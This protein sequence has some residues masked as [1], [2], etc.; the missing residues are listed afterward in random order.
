MLAPL[1]PDMFDPACPSAL[2]P[3]RVG[4]KWGAMI[5]RCLADGPRRFGELRVPLHGITPK[6]LTSSLRRLERDG[7]VSRTELAGPVRQVEYA[8]T[9]LG[10]SLLDPLDAACAWASAHWDEILDAADAALA[11]EQAVAH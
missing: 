5:V 6:V 8:L 11:R 10:R 7:Y 3:V 2:T 4:T 1:D 9:P